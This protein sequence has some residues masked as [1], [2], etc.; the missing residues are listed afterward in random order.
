MKKTQ[1]FWDGQNPFPPWHLLPL[2]SP[3]LSSLRSSKGKNCLI[4]TSFLAGDRSTRIAYCVGC[5]GFTSPKARKENSHH[6]DGDWKSQS[7]NLA[8]CHWLGEVDPTYVNEEDWKGILFWH[9]FFEKSGD[10]HLGC[11]KIPMN[12]KENQSICCCRYWRISSINSILGESIRPFPPTNGSSSGYEEGSQRRSI[13]P[14]T[15]PP[16]AKW[17]ASSLH[18]HASS[19]WVI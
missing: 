13:D 9:C 8:K 12:K 6:Q 2:G 1:N 14:P 15:N 11:I 7:L 3:K 4:P 5:I 10:H 16:L 19:R 17:Q 18:F